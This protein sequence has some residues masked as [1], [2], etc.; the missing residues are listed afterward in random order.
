MEEGDTCLTTSSTSS[1]VERSG[2]MIP[3]A[4]ASKARLIIHLSL[5]AILTSG[6]TPYGAIFAIHSCIS[7]VNIRSHVH[8]TTIFD[9]DEEIVGKST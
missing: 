8:R 6:L 5:S 1:I 4:P 3:C 2:T 7:T 9:D